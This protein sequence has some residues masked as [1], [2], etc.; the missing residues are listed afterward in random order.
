[1]VELTGSGPRKPVGETLGGD[2]EGAFCRLIKLPLPAE[3]WSCKW[4]VGPRNSTSTLQVAGIA[5]TTSLPRSRSRGSILSGKAER[6]VVHGK[7]SFSPS[8][9]LAAMVIGAI[10]G[11]RRFEGLLR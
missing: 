3:T 4:T 6:A 10:R 2:G 11:R 8:V 9:S 7:S 1:V 5:W